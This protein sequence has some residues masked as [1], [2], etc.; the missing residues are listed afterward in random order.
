MEQLREA[1]FRSEDV[2]PHE[3]ERGFDMLLPQLAKLKQF[4][5]ITSLASIYQ[6][7]Q[8]VQ[9]ASYEQARLAFQLAET[10]D[11]DLL[12]SRLVQFAQLHIALETIM[13][14]QQAHLWSDEQWV[15]IRSRL[16][17]FNLPALIPNSLRAERAVGYSYVEPMFTQSWS[18]A[19]KQM[20]HLGAAGKSEIETGLWMTLLDSVASKFS[21]AFLAKQWRLCMEAYSLMIEDLEQGVQASYSGPWKEI[22]TTWSDENLLQYGVFAKMLIPALSQAQ[23]KAFLMQLKIE[24]AK[25]AIDLER[26]YLK[27]GHYPDAL[28]ALSPAFRDT[29]P[30]DP[31][32]R[33]ML[34]YEKVEDAGFELYSVGMN[35]EDDQ[36]RHAV[37]PKRNENN[38]PDDLL[39]V[40][41]VNP[42]ELPS[43]HVDE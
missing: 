10:G 1:V 18:R 27:H 32:T 37:K 40:I 19:M 34:K 5:Q 39:W 13:S 29:T 41:R 8:G 17:K 6:S 31:M 16:D 14:A 35:G 33:K 21:Q 9:D 20:D 25:T 26:Y 2:Y 11:S 7:I 3:W 36:G 23:N 30:L 42:P 24:L 4:T 12:I 38:P 28:G 22:H 43:F 15:Q